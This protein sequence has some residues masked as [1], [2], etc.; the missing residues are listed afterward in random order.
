M[1]AAAFCA[2]VV[3]F[4]GPRTMLLPVVVV[5]LLLSPAVARGRLRPRRRGVEDDMAAGGALKE[6]FAPVA[7][8]RAPLPPMYLL[9]VDVVLV[10]VSV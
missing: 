9:C 4:T 3:G 10:R 1:A 8:P 5:L 6:C 7:G 2:P